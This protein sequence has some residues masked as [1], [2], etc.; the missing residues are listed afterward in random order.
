M[1]AYYITTAT[2][3]RRLCVE[4]DFNSD[5]TSLWRYDGDANLP[6]LDGAHWKLIKTDAHPCRHCRCNVSLKLAF[7]TWYTFRKLKHFSDT[8]YH[9]NYRDRECESMHHVGTG[10]RVA[11]D[12]MRIAERTQLWRKF[13]DWILHWP[14]VSGRFRFIKI[15]S[16][17][18]NYR[19]S[20]FLSGN[21]NTQLPNANT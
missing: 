11:T 12:K 3:V 5:F 9:L 14:V 16:K 19:F 18:R 21:V 6:L 20:A 8:F 15:G 2:S 10:V 1:H 7:T 17:C 13:V 4:V